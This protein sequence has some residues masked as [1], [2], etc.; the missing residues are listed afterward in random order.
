MPEFEDKEFTFP[1]EVD[2]KVKIDIEGSNEIDIEIEDDT[3]E[4]DRN[5]APMPKEIVDDLEKDNDLSLKNV[6]LVSIG[7]D[8]Q[9]RHPAKL[10]KLA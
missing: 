7:L 2:E 6:E 4:Q 5:R 1:D 3:P 8:I 9:N 10:H